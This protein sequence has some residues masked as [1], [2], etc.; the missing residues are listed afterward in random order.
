METLEDFFGRS[1]TG[2]IIMTKFWAYIPNP[3]STDDTFI[4]DII[5]DKEYQD[6]S[7]TYSLYNHEEAVLD[8]VVHTV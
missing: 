8:V 2:N 4:V 7:F 1:L 3:L 5:N 6:Y